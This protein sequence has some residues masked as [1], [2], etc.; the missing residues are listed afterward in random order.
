[1][2]LDEEDE[3]FAKIKTKKFSKNELFLV[4]VAYFRLYLEAKIL[5]LEL[6]YKH[7]MK[8]FEN[9]D[10]ELSKIISDQAQIDGDTEVIKGKIDENMLFTFNKLSQKI[11]DEQKEVEEDVGKLNSKFIFFN[12]SNY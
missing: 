11:G 3:R 9:K 12:D 4:K 10:A 7:L 8:P 1:M 6:E 5:N 2:F